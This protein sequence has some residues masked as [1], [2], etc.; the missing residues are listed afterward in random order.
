MSRINLL[1][2]V[3]VVKEIIQ[4]VGLIK[5]DARGRVRWR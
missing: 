2:L 3:D 1:R 4:R 5:L